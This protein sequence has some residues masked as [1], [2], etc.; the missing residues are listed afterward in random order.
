MYVMYDQL[1]RSVIGGKHS[2]TT[3]FSKSHGF[4][5]SIEKHRGR[6]RFLASRFATVCTIIPIDIMVM[7]IYGKVSVFYYGKEPKCL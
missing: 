1:M 5:L 7:V 4:V 6:C 2:K 3:M